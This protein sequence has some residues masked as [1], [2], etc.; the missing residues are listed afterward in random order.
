MKKENLYNIILLKSRNFVLYE[1]NK[2]EDNLQNKIIILLLHFSFILNKIKKY[3]LHH[4]QEIFDYIILKIDTDLREIGIGDMSI[5]KKMK[6]II[7]KFYSILIDFDG[8]LQK[9]SKIKNNMFAK[10]FSYS[11]N[12]DI[13]YYNL[14]KYFDKFGK[15]IDLISADDIYRANLK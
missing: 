8:F 13:K 6:F 3:N 14:V 4:N 10:L 9:S 12:K 1:K 7:N 2:I 11:N 5:N 15:T